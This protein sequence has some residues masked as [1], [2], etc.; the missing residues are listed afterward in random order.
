MASISTVCGKTVKIIDTPGFFDGF[1]ATE[2]NF[3]KLSK[4]VTLAKEG[5]HAL[6]FVLGRYTDSCEQ[7]IKQL[8]L[9]RGI[10][11]FM[12][13]L[14]T[15]AENEGQNEVTTKEYIKKVL[16]SPDCPNGFKD[17]MKMVDNRVIM[18]ETVKDVASDYHE[19]KSKEFM[20]TIESLIEINEN[21]VYTNAML[22]LAAQIYEEAKRTQDARLQEATEVIKCNSEKIKQLKCQNDDTLTMSSERSNEIAALEE[23]IDEVQSQ[24]SEIEDP[25]YIADITENILGKA[26]EEAG[27]A[28][29]EDGVDKNNFA[30]FVKSFT[31]YVSVSAV[32]APTSGALYAGIGAGIGAVV[33]SFFPVIGTGAGAYAGAQIVGLIGSTTVLGSVAHSFWHTKN[34]GETREGFSGVIDKVKKAHDYCKTT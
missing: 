32:I 34:E 1:T 15:H 14:L 18:L 33:G 21:K 27:E 12:F 8:L 11:P 31:G 7:A 9:F 13:V 5:I 22:Q 4:V 20:S 24:C 17:L 6:A 10:Q 29:V 19:Q 16:S 30:D 3:Q 28:M 2:G 23:A 25:Q 26:M